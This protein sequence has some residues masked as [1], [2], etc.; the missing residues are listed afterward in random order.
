MTNNTAL[1]SGGAV[2]V[3]GQNNN[4][5]NNNFTQNKAKT[6]AVINNLGTN[7]NI[8]SNIMQYNTATSLGGAISNW[9]AKY[10]IITGNRIHH[11]QA[12][13]GAIYLRGT[14][15]TVQSNNIYNNK[16]TSSGGAI[17]N[18]GTNNTITENTIKNND[19]KSYG[20]AINNYNAVNT[21]ITNNN[22]TSNNASYGG[23]IYT[24]ATNTTIT[25]NKITSNTANSGGAI[26]DMKHATTT[27][28][29]NT[30]KNNPTKNGH[31]EVY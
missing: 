28:N 13:Y 6:G 18:I 31:E 21:K 19:A 10:I 25:G 14:N 22:L 7:I 27:I 5:T 1:V 4:I 17:Y 24:R 16:A 15:I 3:I 26:F 9:N 12:Q 23:A 29:H 8:K 2:F 11:N 30:I 20:G